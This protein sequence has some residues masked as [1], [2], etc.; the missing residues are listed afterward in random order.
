MEEVVIVNFNI[1]KI[2][3]E[4]RIQTYVGGRRIHSFSG[5][6]MDCLFDNNNGEYQRL[7]R[8]L[9]SAVY[10]RNKKFIFHEDI[11]EEFKTIIKYEWVK[12]HKNN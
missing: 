7:C 6:P 10:G 5:V 1:E 2:H 9:K 3:C 8:N 4:D 12:I 11:P